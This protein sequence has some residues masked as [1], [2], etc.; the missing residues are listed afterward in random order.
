MSI[1]NSV[2]K[3]AE[4]IIARECGESKY[5]M[6]DIVDLTT[7]TGSIPAELIVEEATRSYHAGNQYTALFFSDTSK[8]PADLDTILTLCPSPAL[9]IVKISPTGKKETVR[10]IGC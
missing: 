1:N 7:E 6:F 3:F 2:T 5:G 8:L 9:L 4:N 10:R